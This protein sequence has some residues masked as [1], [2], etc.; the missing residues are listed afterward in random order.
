[1]CMSLAHD[2]VYE[3]EKTGGFSEAFPERDVYRL[4]WFVITTAG[5]FGQDYLE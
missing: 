2:S 1:M 5:H 4:V 3:Y